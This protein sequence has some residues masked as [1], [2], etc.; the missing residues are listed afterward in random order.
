MTTLEPV[1]ELNRIV[2]NSTPNILPLGQIPA[3]KGFNVVFQI[4]IEWLLRLEEDYQPKLTFI[5]SEG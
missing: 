2:Y 1:D 5:T 4:K 3:V